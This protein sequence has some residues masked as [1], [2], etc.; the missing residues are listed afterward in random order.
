VENNRTDLPNSPELEKSILGMMIDNRNVLDELL[1]IIDKS[2]IFFN[3]RNETIF[4]TLRDLHK[5]GYPTD[6]TTLSET[7]R[8]AAR[9]DEVGGAWYVTELVSKT[10][11][12][13]AAF[14]QAIGLK[15]LYLR[16]EQIRIGY[17]LVGLAQDQTNDVFEIFEKAEQ[18]L[19]NLSQVATINNASKLST[20]TDRLIKS[21]YEVKASPDGLTGVSTGFEGINDKTN[22][23][24]DTDLIIVA[25][26]PSVGKTAFSLNLAYNA[27]TDKIK[28]VSAVI[29]NLEMG[30][31]QLSK[32]VMS[33]MSGVDLEKINKPKSLSDEELT[34]ISDARTRQNAIKMFIDDTPALSVPQLRSKLRRLIKK[35]NVGLV[36]IDYLQLMKGDTKRN[37]NREQ[38]IS[39]ISRDLK[40]V[41]K[42]LKIPIIALS[43]LNRDIE[44]RANKE[45]QLSDLRESGAIEQDADLIIF[46]YRPS[47]EA[48]K[49]DWTLKNVVMASIKKHRN[50]NTFDAA[51]EFK[52][53]IQLFSQPTDFEKKE[54]PKNPDNP[55]A[56]ISGNYQPSRQLPKEKDDLPF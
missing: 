39:Q 3:S 18:Q 50:G 43:Q 28:P 54:E 53:E 49:E 55:S 47:E 37:G 9:L 32:R 17:E 41:A 46:L 4:S 15:E 44:K 19:F 7:L 22:G 10:H 35:H 42:E 8:K 14:H 12:I 34:L 27:A 21:I 24:Q 13:G 2:E 20:V 11:G 29:F 26:R 48:I 6:L 5:S 45:P 30:D 16:R 56:G 51:L 1:E 36:V 52:K 25:A 40:V 23:W 33:A 31:L 38:E